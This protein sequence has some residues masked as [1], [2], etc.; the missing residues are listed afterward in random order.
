MTQVSHM[1]DCDTRHNRNYFPVVG[2]LIFAIALA[3]SRRTA[4]NNNKWE[5]A[6]FDLR[7]GD[8][9]DDELLNFVT[10]HENENADETP[11]SQPLVF[12]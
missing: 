10:N 9:G 8:I 7:F 12:M 4:D 5:M 1:T 6:S 11:W 3:I 2:P